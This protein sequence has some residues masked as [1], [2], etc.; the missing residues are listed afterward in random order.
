MLL[1]G[2]RLAVAGILTNKPLNYR[3]YAERIATPFGTHDQSQTLAMVVYQPIG[4][5]PFPTIVMN[6]GSTGL[7]NSPERFKYVWTSVPLGRY[8]V[9][10]GWGRS[11]FHSV[12]DAAALTVSTRRGWLQMARVRCVVPRRHWPV[13]NGR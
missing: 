5:G 1:K 11:C 3:R 6:H 9:D 10:R 7:G 13:E 12:A 2:G 8:F 4:P